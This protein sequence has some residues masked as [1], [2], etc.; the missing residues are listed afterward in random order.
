M[1]GPDAGVEP[2]MAV[3][4]AGPGADGCHHRLLATAMC[5]CEVCDMCWGEI[6]GSKAGCMGDNKREMKIPTSQRALIPPRKTS[7]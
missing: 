4:P 6:G 7:G 3:L 1:S 5:V 2:Q